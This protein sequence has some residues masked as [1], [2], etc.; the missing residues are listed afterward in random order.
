MHST[1][2]II[3]LIYMNFKI[4]LYVIKM[5]LEFLYT[6][7]RMHTTYFCARNLTQNIHLPPRPV[8]HHWLGYKIM[9][10]TNKHRYPCP[11]ETYPYIYILLYIVFKIL[12]L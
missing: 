1:L 5:F 3:L 4:H 7:S 11:E 10:L 2:Y 8:P 12:T 6:T 9:N